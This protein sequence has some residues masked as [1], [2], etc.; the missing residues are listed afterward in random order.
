VIIVG[1]AKTNAL[2]VLSLGG[3]HP[4]PILRPV[5]FNTAAVRT[6]SVSAE[7]TVA[8]A[9]GEYG[10]GFRVLVS[11]GDRLEVSEPFNGVVR[12][13][14]LLRDL[15][16]AVVETDTGLVFQGLKIGDNGK[17][18]AP[19]FSSFSLESGSWTLRVSAE[20]ILGVALTA[21]GALRT[22]HWDVSD[23]RATLGEI[24]EPGPPDSGEWLDLYDARFSTSGPSVFIS[25]EWGID[26]GGP[27]D[28]ADY[29]ISFRPAENEVLGAYAF[30][31]AEPSDACP[32]S[33]QILIGDSLATVRS[34]TGARCDPTIAVDADRTLTDAEG[35]HYLPRDDAPPA[36]AAL[37]P[38]LRVVEIPGLQT[39]GAGLDYSLGSQDRFVWFSWVA[40]RLAFRDPGLKKPSP[41]M[42]GVDGRVFGMDSTRGSELRRVSS[43]MAGAYDLSS[44]RW[45]MYDARGP[46][47]LTTGA[48]ECGGSCGLEPRVLDRIP[49][50]ATLLPLLEA[51]AYWV[52]A[53]DAIQGFP[54]LVRQP[55]GKPAEMYPV[56]D[57]RGEFPYSPTQEWDYTGL[58]RNLNYADPAVMTATLQGQCSL[59]FK[60]GLAPE[61]RIGIRGNLEWVRDKAGDTDWLLAILEGEG[62]RARRIVGFRMKTPGKVAGKQ[63][64]TRDEG[65]LPWP[66][67]VF[68]LEGEDFVLNDRPEGGFIL[69]RTYTTYP[70]TCLSLEPV[71]WTDTFIISPGAVSFAGT[72]VTS[73]FTDDPC[74]RREAGRT[75]DRA[76]YGNDET[77]GGMPE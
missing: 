77:E 76:K 47:V 8:I 5:D 14:A 30:W 25:A 55:S 61:V 12:A 38:S 58:V 32:D 9:V 26:S 40:E 31:S 44:G 17:V 75:L 24:A 59:G 39:L 33:V 49:S 62:T 16:A 56:I 42:S 11:D 10:E 45:W 69:R 7:R 57:R 20:G 1:S 4:E 63:P 53:T 66:E 50:D 51:S 34:D 54:C 73:G 23:D 21:S 72:K 46:R 28:R 29:L 3:V 60:D 70:K 41:G 13:A 37:A 2:S 48:P 71:E 65:E 52:L 74:V 36:P 68:S 43:G 18:A 64:E 19:G 22:V 35:N 6:I 67:I 15:L 27:A